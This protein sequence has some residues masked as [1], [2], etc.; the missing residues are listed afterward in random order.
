MLGYVYV[1][2]GSLWTS[3]FAHFVNNGVLVLCTY[4]EQQNKLP[5]KIEEVGGGEGELSYVIGSALVASLLLFLVWQKRKEYIFE[6]VVNTHQDG[7]NPEVQ[8]HG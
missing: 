6:D 1:W 5:Q 7:T 8:H 3:I 4:L 2:S